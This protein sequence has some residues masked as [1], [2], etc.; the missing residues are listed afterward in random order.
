[1][2]PL[3]ASLS[4]CT[5]IPYG[6]KNELHNDYFAEPVCAMIVLNMREFREVGQAHVHKISNSQ[7]KLANRHRMI[8][9]NWSRIDPQAKTKGGSR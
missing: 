9:R 1:M 5:S 6:V 7:W 3:G 2:E 4:Q 8:N